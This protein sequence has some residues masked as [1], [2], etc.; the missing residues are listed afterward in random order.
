LIFSERK[1]K[2]TKC[3]SSGEMNQKHSVQRASL[4]KTPPGPKAEKKAT[5]RNNEKEALGRTHYTYI[6]LNASI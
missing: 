1:E 2:K 4:K 3:N 6:S 5:K